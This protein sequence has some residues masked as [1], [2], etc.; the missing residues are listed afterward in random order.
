MGLVKL[1][2][3]FSLIVLILLLLFIFIANLSKQLK[4]VTRDVAKSKDI[5]LALNQYNNQLERLEEV[6]TKSKEQDFSIFL[7]P[8]LTQVKE[9]RLIL[10]KINVKFDNLLGGTT[11]GNE[12]NVWLTKANEEP[13]LPRRVEIIES[14]LT[15]FPGHRPLMELYEK[16]IMQMHSSNLN[17]IQKQVIERFNRTAR[18]YRSYCE[19]EDYP[20]ADE[21]V[22]KA[23]QLGNQFINDFDERRKNQLIKSITALEEKFK[24]LE[25]NQVISKDELN[26]LEKLDQQIDKSLLSREAALQQKY[27]SISKKVVKLLTNDVSEMSLNDYNLRALEAIKKAH[28]HFMKNE[29][30]LKSGS[31]LGDLVVLLGGWDMNAFH[32]STQVYYQSIY[33]DIFTKLEPKAKTTF[34]ELM[35]KSNKKEVS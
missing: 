6:I 18:T 35:L 29:K 22:D 12:I 16:V 2:W 24:T 27:S 14:A 17:A 5:E 10:E 28:L 25:N 21:M 11:N 4:D 19:I 32:L 15:R 9:N 34:T 13:S 30:I 31:H 8:L 20:Y 3:I 1:E 26:E 23:I 7:S 33:S